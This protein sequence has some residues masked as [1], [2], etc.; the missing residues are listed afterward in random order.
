[1]LAGRTILYLQFSWRGS[2]IEFIYKQEGNTFEGAVNHL[3]QKNGTEGRSTTLPS[4]TQTDRAVPTHQLPF[5]FAST[6]LCG[7]TI[8]EKEKAD[9]V[10]CQ[11]KNHDYWVHGLA[12]INPCLKDSE[13]GTLLN[14][15]R[16]FSKPRNSRPLASS[17]SVCRNRGSFC[18]FTDHTTHHS[19]TCLI[20]C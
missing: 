12:G 6:T 14:S 13:M 4:A 16:P 17:C 2:N 9:L 7:G 8:S 11:R 15:W 19:N 1:M 3:L 20:M 5:S 18:S 10:S